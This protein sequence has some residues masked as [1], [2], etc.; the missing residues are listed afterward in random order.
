MENTLLQVKCT[1]LKYV[2]SALFLFYSFLLSFNIWENLVNIYIVPLKDILCITVLNWEWDCCAENSEV[3]LIMECQIFC[4]PAHIIVCIVTHLSVL[5]T[6]C[7]CG[8]FACLF[9]L[10]ICIPR[11]GIQKYACNCVT[12]E[13]KPVFSMWNLIAFNLHWRRKLFLSISIT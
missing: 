7:T 10:F 2:C 6:V 1:N 9:K 11:V 3:I 4:I 13:S 5:L 8:H 12:W